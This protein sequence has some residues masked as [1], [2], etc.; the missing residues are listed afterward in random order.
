MLWDEYKKK[1]NYMN[2][3]YYCYRAA[4][5]RLDPLEQDFE[6]KFKKLFDEQYRIIEEINLITEEQQRP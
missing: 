2:L 6:A 5:N 1:L 4:I 3:L